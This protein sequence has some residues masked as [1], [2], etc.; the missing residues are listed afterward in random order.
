MARD[1]LE[2]RHLYDF[3]STKENKLSP[4]I[5]P[6]P[7][8]QLA[9]EGI[10]PVSVVEGVSYEEGAQCGGGSRWDKSLGVLCQKFVMLFLVT[11]VSCHMTSLATPP[12]TPFCTI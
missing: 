4:S 1:D 9:N 3:K 6:A 2:F 8:K 7:V 10:V 11:P 5:A 12:T